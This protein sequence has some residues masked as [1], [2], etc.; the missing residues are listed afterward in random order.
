MH[1]IHCADK[2]LKVSLAHGKKNGL[3]KIQKITIELGKIIEHGEE[4]NAENLKFN[5]KL[6]AKNTIAQNVKISILK[7]I[8]TQGWKLIEIEG[9]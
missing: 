6:L 1:D 8:S 5:L 3:K 9:E 4:I 2:I 7:N